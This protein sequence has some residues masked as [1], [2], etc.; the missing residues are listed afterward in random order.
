MKKPTKKKPAPQRGAMKKRSAKPKASKETVLVLRTCSANLTSHGGFVWPESGLVKC[1]DW[2]PAPHCGN[3][4]HGL[5]WGAGAGNLLDWTPEA[6]WQ[7]V[8]VEADAVVAIDGGEKVKFPQG[9]VVY[10]GERA[11][12]VELIASRAPAG[13]AITAA[14]ATA[15]ARG[16]ATAGYAGTATAGARGTATAGDAGT[17]TAGDE[18]TAPAGERVTATSG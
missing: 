3:G 6:K 7:V 1:P 9:I 5:L 11:G 10:C 14:T 16:T 4:L 13:T 17:A 2:K 12:A 15:G 8:E 18:G